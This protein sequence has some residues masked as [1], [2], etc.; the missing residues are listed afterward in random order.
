MKDVLGNE[1]EVGH[2]VQLVLPDKF[3]NGYVTKITAG[4]VVSGRRAGRD[5]VTPA[6]IE[7]QCA[8]TIPLDPMHPQL[9]AVVRVVDPN[10]TDVEAKEE[11][12]KLIMPN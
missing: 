4:G 10:A 8:F 7:I 6:T 5:S 2:R 12:P 9:S 3:V 1:L 11:G